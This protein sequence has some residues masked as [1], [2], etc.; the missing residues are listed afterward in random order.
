MLTY[1]QSTNRSATNVAHPTDV[2]AQPAVVARPR[3]TTTATMAT[4]VVTTFSTART[5]TT[6]LDLIP[7]LSVTILL[8]ILH[9]RAITTT[10]TQKTNESFDGLVNIG[11]GRQQQLTLN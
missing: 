10:T 4:G 3:L 7:A 8:E 11:A 5:A 9:F 1:Q 6:V 2:L